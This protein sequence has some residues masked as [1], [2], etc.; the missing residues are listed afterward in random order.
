MVPVRK[1]HALNITWALPPQ[2]KHYRWA[3]HWACSETVKC[4]SFIHKRVSLHLLRKVEPLQKQYDSPALQ[5]SPFHHLLFS[6]WNLS[7][8]SP[9]WLATKAQEASSRCSGRSECYCLCL[10]VFLIGGPSTTQ[11]KGLQFAGYTWAFPGSARWRPIFK[12]A[13]LPAH[14]TAW[15]IPSHPW[16]WSYSRGAF[17]PL[18]AEWQSDSPTLCSPTAPRAP[19][20]IPLPSFNG[21][22]LFTVFQVLINDSGDTWVHSRSIP[23]P[24]ICRGSGVVVFIEFTQSPRGPRGRCQIGSLLSSVKLGN[25]LSVGWSG[26]SKFRVSAQQLWFQVALSEN[27]HI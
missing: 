27:G 17:Q 3:P 8:T 23:S 18:V 14:L 22:F 21:I 4:M 25:G 2:E 19:P 7:A 9:G 6:E 10:F 15:F 26:V 20:I 5:R 1:V 11:L 12:L 16:M 13:S 24:T